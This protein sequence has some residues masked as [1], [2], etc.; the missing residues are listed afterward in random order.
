MKILLPL[1][2]I[3]GLSSFAH[4]IL[5]SCI[6]EAGPN[7]VP[8]HQ[9]PPG[10]K[11]DK[12]NRGVTGAPGVQGPT[13]PIGQKGDRGQKGEPGSRVG[14]RGP[15]GP[16]GLTGVCPVC[17]VPRSTMEE[18]PTLEPN[19]IYRVTETGDLAAVRK[20]NPSP[21]VRSLLKEHMRSLR[22]E[23]GGYDERTE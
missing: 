22:Q 5:K 18:E 17:R 10:Q 13:G 8:G 14:P 9:G 20:V 11:G 7:G 4:A 2:L 21:A 23:E 16:V 1:L 6:C 15:P 12:G 19:T 3:L